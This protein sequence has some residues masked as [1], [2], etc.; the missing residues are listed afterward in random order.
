MNAESPKTVYLADYQPFTHRVTAVHLTFRLAPK[1]TQVLARLEL[2]PNPARGQG[3]DL[4]LDGEGLRLIGARLNGAV[5]DVTPDD[6]GLT[7]AAH[8]LPQGDFTLETE[9]EISPEGNFALEGLY[10]SNG[11]YCTQCEAQGFR[12]IT[13]YPDRPDVMASY[14]VTLRA[15][16]AQYP[17]LL[18]NGNLVDSGALEELTL[19][20]NGSQLAKYAQ[21]LADIGV[22]RVNVSMDTLDPDKFRQLTRW[23]DLDQVMRGLDAAQRAGQQHQRQYPPRLG[24]VEV[25]RHATG[26]DGTH[27]E[28]AVRADVG[29]IGA[30]AQ[31]Q[32]HA[33]QDQRGGL[34]E[35][36]SHPIQAGGRLDE[37]NVERVQRVLPQ[38]VEQH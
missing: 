13:F 12:H 25:Q 2:Q 7:I 1:T 22:R 24:A 32:P 34:E 27:G 8:L 37:V 16:K 21:E 30:E 9:V 4:R 35:Q 14:T 17:V 31:R 11:M 36:F 3:H 33:A 5:L 19:T 18:S 28:L 26:R 23:G 6:T 10:M 15:D 38:H 20:T 29:D